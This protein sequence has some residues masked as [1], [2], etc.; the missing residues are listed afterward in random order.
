MIDLSVRSQHVCSTRISITE[1]TCHFST[2][3]VEHL[4]A[5]GKKTFGFFP[6]ISSQN[7]VNTPI[8]LSNSSIQP[9]KKAW[10]LYTK[11]SGIRPEFFQLSGKSGIRPDSKKHYPGTPSSVDCVVVGVLIQWKI[12][13][14]ESV[15]RSF[16]LVLFSPTSNISTSRGIAFHLTST[17]CCQVLWQAFWLDL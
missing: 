4:W 11:I 15:R 9:E 2:I 7:M 10:A 16:R 17:R 12:L 3:H 6:I 13:Q 5:L 14:W 8:F 1:N